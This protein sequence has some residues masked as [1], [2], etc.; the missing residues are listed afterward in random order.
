MMM[1]DIPRSV[2]EDARAVMTAQWALG[3]DRTSDT[4]IRFI[5]RALL[6]RDKR[7]AGIARAYAD[8]EEI[9]ALSGM[10]ESK[11]VKSPGWIKDAAHSQAQETA[12]AIAEAIET[13][14]DGK[15]D[16]L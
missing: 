13:Y 6:A 11:G 5:A 16:G 14:P 7:A 15:E 1:T 8:S 9:K 12:E 4:L 2:M 10:A 3:Y